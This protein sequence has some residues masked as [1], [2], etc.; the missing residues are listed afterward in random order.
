M[1]KY[2]PSYP[3]L[4]IYQLKRAIALQRSRQIYYLSLFILYPA[5][6]FRFRPHNIIRKRRSIFIF[7]VN[8]SSNGSFPN[9]PRHIFHQLKRSSLKSLPSN[10]PP[11]LQ[12][13]IK[14]TNTVI[15]ISALDISCIN[16]E[17]SSFIADR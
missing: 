9:F 3:I 7:V 8:F 13:N 17:F 12:L 6:L 5:V 16:F 4:K 14:K 15:V 1:P 11:I 10:F 2:I